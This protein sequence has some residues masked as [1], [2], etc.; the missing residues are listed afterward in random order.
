MDEIKSFV[1]QPVLSQILSC[2]PSEIISRVVR[3]HKSNHYFKRIPFRV[4]LVGLLYGVFS[5][6]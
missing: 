3:T 2:I 4:H 1:G 5:Y 6:W